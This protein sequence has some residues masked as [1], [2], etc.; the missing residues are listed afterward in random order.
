MVFIYIHSMI[1]KPNSIPLHMIGYND[2]INVPGEAVEMNG[3]IYW[4][5]LEPDPLDPNP[6]FS[7]F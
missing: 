3:Y 5:A 1:I 7:P 2:L 6:S 4:L